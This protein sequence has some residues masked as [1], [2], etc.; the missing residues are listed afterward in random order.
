MKKLKISNLITIAAFLLILFISK[1]YSNRQLYEAGIELAR[2]ECT[3]N[4]I[5]YDEFLKKIN[6]EGRRKETL[7]KVKNEDIFLTLEFVGDTN[8][9]MS[10][11]QMSG[12]WR[13]SLPKNCIFNKL[14]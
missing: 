3:I 6:S 2:K 5:L 7:C 9:T 1:I 14:E 12:F 11:D 4:V 10:C 8:I 13:P